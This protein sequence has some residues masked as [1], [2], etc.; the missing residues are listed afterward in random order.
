VIFC[1]YLLRL[2]GDGEMIK[3]MKIQRLIIL[4]LPLVG[5]QAG[6]FSLVSGR[7]RGRT[8]GRG[9]GGAEPAPL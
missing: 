7:A 2:T 6:G 3:R 8:G 5:G 1:D 4:L 9:A